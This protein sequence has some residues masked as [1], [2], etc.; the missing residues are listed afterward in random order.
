LVSHRS[1]RGQRI[2]LRQTP[3]DG[4]LSHDNWNDL[5]SWGELSYDLH[6]RKT[7]RT[8]G[9]TYGFVAG[10]HAGW[11]G[12]GIDKPCDE[13]YVLEQQVQIEHLFAK[14]GD[15]GA[16]VIDRDGRLV[17]F[18][19]GGVELRDIKIIVDKKAKIPDLLEY[20]KRR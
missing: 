11:Q 17:G 8:S 2:E 6:V 7:G 12:N 20:E 9:T 18:V 10:V 5:S 13:F 19:W 4:V 3:E 16:V 15:S 14:K 1:P